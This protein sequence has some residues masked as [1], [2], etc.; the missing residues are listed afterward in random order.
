MQTLLQQDGVSY[1]LV[2]DDIEVG[3]IQGHVVK[4]VYPPNDWQPGKYIFN[5]GRWLANPE[6]SA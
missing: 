2:P 3:E 4:S 1:R 6:W 5:S